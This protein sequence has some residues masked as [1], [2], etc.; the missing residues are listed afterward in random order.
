MSQSGFNREQQCL[1]IH[2]GK[3]QHF[4]GVG[5]HGDAWNDPVRV[6]LG[7][8]LGAFLDLL[9]AGAGGKCGIS[10]GWLRHRW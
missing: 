1:F 7:C 4:L 3:H 5:V 6:E 2:E 9:N 10:L 8:K